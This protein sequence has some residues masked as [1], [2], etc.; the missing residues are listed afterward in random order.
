MVAGC[1]TR[2]GI[3]GYVC[4]GRQT[5]YTGPVNSD[6]RKQLHDFKCEAQEVANSIKSLIGEGPGGNDWWF[7]ST[8]GPLGCE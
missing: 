2:P 1:R 8:T 4:N 5:E 7:T 3:P 6:L